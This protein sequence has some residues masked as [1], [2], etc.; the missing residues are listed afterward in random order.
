MMSEENLLK[1]LT[2]PPKRKQINLQLMAISWAWASKLLMMPDKELLT[3]QPPL[4]NV[5]KTLLMVKPSLPKEL[6]ISLDIDK[7][8]LM[9][10]KDGLR[11]LQ[12]SINSSQ[13]SRMNRMPSTK[14]STS[15][16][17]S[18]SP[19]K[20]WIEWISDIL[21]VILYDILPTND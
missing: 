8:L 1:A 9:N 7:T 6:K 20:P 16:Y 14:S 18:M 3:T 2:L 10:L 17:P 19:L 4:N 15:V 5:Y 11:L 13:N 12:Y 21:R